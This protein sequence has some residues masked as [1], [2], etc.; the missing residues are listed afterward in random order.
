VLTKTGVNAQLVVRSR[1]DV[2]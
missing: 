2:L 1:P